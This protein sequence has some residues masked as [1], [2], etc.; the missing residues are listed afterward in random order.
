MENRGLGVG[1]VCPRTIHLHL[2]GWNSVSAWLLTKLRA[3]DRMCF[4]NC[5]LDPMATTT[6]ST[7]GQIPT[8]VVRATE[9]ML[10]VKHLDR[11]AAFMARA[12]NAITQIASDIDERALNDIAGE[13]SDVEVLM[14]V[15][16]RPEILDALDGDVPCATTTIRGLPMRQRL[17][18]AEGGAVSSARAASILRVSRQ[19]VDKRRRNG[20][21]IGV[22]VGR[23]GYAYP[24]WQ[25]DAQ[26]GMAPG[27]EDVL[28]ALRDLD[29]W[30][31]MIFMLN[32]NA[33]LENRSP[34]AALRDGAVSEVVRAAQAFG[35]HGAV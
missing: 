3:W 25:F 6:L 27:M 31:K 29:P 18:E 20:R 28:D 2:P 32:G 34:L 30:M 35:E 16:A 5:G 23:R 33:R 22:S 10:R 11:K 21:L 1:A 17:I 8:A 9:N 7:T 13:R 15:L 19:A 24:A 12:I 14:R 4:V 26:R